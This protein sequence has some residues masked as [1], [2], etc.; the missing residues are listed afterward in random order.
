MHVVDRGEGGCI[1]WKG[2]GQGITGQGTNRAG[3]RDNL[4]VRTSPSSVAGLIL[5]LTK[6]KSHGLFQNSGPISDILGTAAVG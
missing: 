3:V 5:I 2:G 4:V 1:G 6:S